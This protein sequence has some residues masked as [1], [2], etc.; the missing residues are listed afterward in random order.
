MKYNELVTIK[1]G[2]NDVF[3][4]ASEQAGY[5]KNFVTNKKFED[6]LIKIL[7]V[8]KSPVDTEHKSIWVQ[9]TYGTGK[10]HSTSV[11]K[12]LLS[13]PLDEVNDFINNLMSSQL[14]S[15]LL[16]FRKVRRIFP[17]VI[18]GNHNISEA[19]DMNSVIQ[20]EVKRAF[21]IA[22]FDL[23]V[24]SDFDTMISTLSDSNFDTFVSN[25]IK[26]D[27]SEYVS[28]KEELFDAL[29][30]EDIGILK[31][32]NKNLKKY[33]LHAASNNIVAWLS[34]VRNFLRKENIAQDLVIFWDE[35]TS[36][37]SISERKS[38]YSLTQDIAEISTTHD[39]GVYMFLITHISYES[40]DVYK[41]MSSNEKEHIRDRFIV[42]PYEIHYDTTYTILYS[43]L[44]RTNP[45]ELEKLV[46][47]RIKRNLE[48]EECLEDVIADTVD[49]NDSKNKLYGLYPFHPYTAYISTFLARIIGS[50]ER[51][52]FNFLNDDNVGFIAFS[53]NETK[54]I[55]FLTIDVLWDFFFDK[56]KE[57]PKYTE[58]VEIYRKN[59][60][61]VKQKG[62][63]YFSLFK[64]ISESFIS[65]SETLFPNVR[66]VAK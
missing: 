28:S 23:S 49:K 63:E 5:W 18:K 26:H 9:G 62:T 15:E 31:I 38:I 13:D 1:K 16:A 32:I 24:K 8:F 42:L 55:P 39:S 11:I 34:E 17:V 64:S 51:S 58:I 19:S 57:N 29:N 41:D 6:N 44:E 2:Y 46:D 12:H 22:G 4:L 30:N 21:K 54:N 33:N 35:F 25:L 53:K 37:L 36:L 52:V 60:D 14:R 50:S 45:N 48:V 66:S 27:L 10:S 7:K 20:T 59:M 56:F 47:E 43:A 3:D 61:S 40:T 65:S